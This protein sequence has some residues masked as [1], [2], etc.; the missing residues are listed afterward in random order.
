ME[1]FVSVLLLLTGVSTAMAGQTDQAR[2]VTGMTLFGGSSPSC[3][4]FIGGILK[5]SP[6][7]QADLQLGDRLIAVDDNP[8]AYLRRAVELLT[9]KAASPVRVDVMRDGKKV[10][11]SLSRRD[12]TTMLKADGWRIFRGEMVPL[13][14]TDPEAEYILNT[15]QEVEHDDISIAFPGHYPANGE[16]YYPGFEAFIW[17][18]QKKVTVGGIEDG[19]AGHAGVRWGDR[20]ISINGI[21]PDSK[22]A[23]ELEALLASR[24]PAKMKL[25]VERAGG[26]K[27]FVFELEQ[28][29][30][31]LRENHWQIINGK[32]VP[33]WVTP[34]YV[35]CFQ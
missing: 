28:V 4:L 3:P 9:S 6:A 29:T 15:Q 35:H 26:R 33:I 11:V 19:P 23:A 14:A 8:V 16:L 5:N 30:S 1:T 20:I 32:K 34:Q 18:K 21:N 10:R 2:Y 24:E 25:T 31:V 27:V 12:I 13:D 22:T 7:S 17:S